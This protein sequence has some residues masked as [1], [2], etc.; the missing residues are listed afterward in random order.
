MRISRTWFLLP[1]VSLFGLGITPLSAQEASAQPT[2]TNTAAVPRVPPPADDIRIFVNGKD[3]TGSR[4]IKLKNVS[5]R[6]DA[7]GNLHVDAPRYQ[8]KLQPGVGRRAPPT[9]APAPVATNNTSTSTTAPAPVMEMKPVRIPPTKRY[10]A[11]IIGNYPSVLGCRITVLVN[12]T[13]V[14]T[15]NGQEA[16]LFVEIT[17]KISRGQ[18]DLEFQCRRPPS[19]QPNSE[20]IEPKMLR[21]AFLEIH[22]GPG[23]INGPMVELDSI[24]GKIRCTDRTGG[25]TESKAQVIVE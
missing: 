13:E 3:V 23:K 16:S 19:A 15:F 9:P 4:N 12:G 8:L 11:S 25:R 6:F 22:V 20:E 18:Q 7:D 1:F 2:E 10:F 17:G 14:A 21:D 24:L 5:L